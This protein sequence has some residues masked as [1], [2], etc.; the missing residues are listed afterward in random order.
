MMQPRCA[1]TTSAPPHTLN[2]TA[3]LQRPRGNRVRPSWNGG[4]LHAPQLSC[5]RPPPCRRHPHVCAA[6]LLPWAPLV[7][8]TDV[9]GLLAVL[10]ACA[11]GGAHAGKHTAVGRALSGPVCAMLLAWTSHTALG[12]LPP[13]GPHFAELQ[14]WF[15][16][17]ATP[18]L[19]LGADVRAIVGRTRRM[20]AAFAVGAA[21]T[22]LG[23]LVGFVLLAPELRPLGDAAG[24]GW[25]LAAALTAK[26]IG[27]GFNYVSVASTTGMSAAALAAGLVADNLAGLVYFPAVSFLGRDAR[28]EADGE[29]GAGKADG[30]PAAVAAPSIEATL[31][32]L[33]LACTLTAVARALSPANSLPVATA[34]AVLLATTA[35]RALSRVAPAGDALGSLLLYLF[36]A[37]AGASAGDPTR[38]AA[39]APLLGFLVV[40]YGVHAGVM[41][42]VCRALGFSLPETLLASNANIGGPATA[43]SLAEAAGW[44]SL[45]TPALLVGSL[46]NAVATF[47]G[48]ALGTGVLSRL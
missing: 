6:S 13:P 1:L 48:L 37:S 24:D 16:Q 27:G 18:A 47:V 45:R 30:E 20:S 38:V 19:L 33:A 26:N 2:T 17:L 29:A 36:F 41:L 3:A 40:L 14:L 4:A 5:R 21:G 28:V 22:T 25:K 46:G 31:A 39:Y 32:A 35:P 42:T 12:V 44:T 43:A 23:A 10:S 7:A 8:S 11:A 15:V 34:L 9:W